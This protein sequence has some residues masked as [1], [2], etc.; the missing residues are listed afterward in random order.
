MAYDV[1]FPWYGEEIIEVY[2]DDFS[3]F[4]NPFDRYLEHLSMLLKLCEE[5]NL[6]LNWE[7]YHFTVKEAIVFGH[8]VFKGG[9]AKERA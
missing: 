3:V 4:D 8:R 1:N 6:L 7:N 5:T 9:I 2:V